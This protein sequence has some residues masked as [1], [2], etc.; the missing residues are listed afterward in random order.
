M[1]SDSYDCSP[2]PAV[3]KLTAHV[4][5]VVHNVF[6]PHHRV[7]FFAPIVL[8]CKPPEMETVTIT[9]TTDAPGGAP[10][11]TPDY[12]GNYGGG[13]Y[14]GSYGS[15]EL[16]GHVVHASVPEPSSVLI[17]LPAFLAVMLATRYGRRA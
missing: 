5:R 11:A 9:A 8:S 14:A 12:P 3:E 10:P 17:M 15:L 2:H 16:E 6:H 13:E 7:H 1:F 4:S